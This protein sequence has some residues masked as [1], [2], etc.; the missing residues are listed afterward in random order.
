MEDCL[1]TLDSNYEAGFV[2]G[3]DL[4]SPR[5]IQAVPQ[6][7]AITKREERRLV[8]PARSRGERISAS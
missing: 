1:D 3:R 4:L 2:I 5:R 7:L 6:G 8:A